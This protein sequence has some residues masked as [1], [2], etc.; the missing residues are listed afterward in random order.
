MKNTL[1]NKKWWEAVAVRSIKTMAEAAVA[2]I[3]V[4]TVITDVDWT[5]VAASTVGAGLVCVLT[6]LA[7]LPE[8]GEAQAEPDE[9][10][11]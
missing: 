5:L 1:L 11:N 10:E 4:S 3:G 2:I 8:V 6:C 7:G 9:E